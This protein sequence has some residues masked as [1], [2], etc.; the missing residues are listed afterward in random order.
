M[1]EIKVVQKKKKKMSRYTMRYLIEKGTKP[2]A[3]DGNDAFTKGHPSIVK[4]LIQ[5]CK[6]I[7]LN[8]KTCINHLMIPI[9][10]NYT[11]FAL[12]SFK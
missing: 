10:H 11:P 5:N 6:K 1:K 4:Y 9:Q 12:T 2:N 3:H 7:D 8:M